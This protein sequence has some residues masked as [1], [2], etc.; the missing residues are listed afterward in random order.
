MRLAKKWLFPL[1]TCLVVLGSVALPRRISEARDAKQLG[2]IHTED[3]AEEDLPV[4]EPPSLMD[5]L[6]LYARWCT[7]S[8]TIPSF[9]SPAILYDEDP[10]QCENLVRQALERLAQAEVIPSHFLSST[11]TITSLNR[12]LLWDPAVSAGR[13]EPME[14]WSVMADLGDG[15]FWMR[16][17]GESGLPLTWSLYDPNMARW[18]PY[19]DPQALPS[20]A[21]RYFALLDLEAA[22][23]GASGDTAL[24]ERHFSTA[25]TGITYEISFNATML[26]IQVTWDTTG[27]ISNFDHSSGFDR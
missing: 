18:L 27:P 17:D 19:K 8:E 14:F 22:E 1:L 10:G 5:R 4:Y 16:L 12:I 21:E 15:S 23:V 2:Q 6:E 7:P 9:Q 25:D 24:W 20:L 13:Q 3:L 11:L 26:N